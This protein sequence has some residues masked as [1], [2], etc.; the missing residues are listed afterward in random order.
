MRNLTRPYWM[1]ANNVDFILATPE[2]LDHRGGAQGPP[3]Q[4]LTRPSA[5][6]E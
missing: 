1:I 4:T 5:T 2:R 6:D 3:S